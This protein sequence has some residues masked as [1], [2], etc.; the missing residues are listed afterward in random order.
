[1]SE[2]ILYEELNL[3]NVDYDKLEFYYDCETES[4]SIHYE[5]LYYW[6]E[7]ILDCPQEMTLSQ[8]QYLIEKIEDELEAYYENDE[9]P[10]QQE[11]PFA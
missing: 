3:R 7:G 4:H 8:E 5:G 11:N 2:E 1:M 10:Y 6:R 9:E